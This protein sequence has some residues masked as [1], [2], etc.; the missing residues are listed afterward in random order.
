MESN[1]K[2]LTENNKK[3]SIFARLTVFCVLMNGFCLLIERVKY[4]LL[5]FFLLIQGL[6]H[7][8]IWSI[9]VRHFIFI[10]YSCLILAR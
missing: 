9:Y 8:L 7:A 10:F 4:I 3:Q 1:G 2:V 6:V 5:L